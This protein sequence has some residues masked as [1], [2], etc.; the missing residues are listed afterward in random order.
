MFKPQ[1]PQQEQGFTLVEV[2]VAILI[3]TLFVGVTM[4]S[5]V[6]AAIF[7][8]RAKQFTEATIWIQ[9]DLE[10]VKFLSTKEQLPFVAVSCSTGYSAALKTKID[11]SIPQPSSDFI[12]GKKFWLVRED[13]TDNHVLK[14]DYSIVPDNNGSAGSTSNAII[15]IHTEVLPDAA[16]ECP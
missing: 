8:A 13:T 4:Q 14:L 3:T 16:F 11:S 5:M 9:K 2:L 1:S 12:G 15:K 10:N 6:I 7:K